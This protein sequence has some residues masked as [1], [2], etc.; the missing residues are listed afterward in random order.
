MFKLAPWLFMSTLLTLV[1]CKPDPVDPAPP[2]EGVL[3]LPETPFNYASP[4]LPDFMM[5]D[6]IQELDNIRQSPHGLGSYT[7]K[8]VVLQLY[9]FTELC[10]ILS[11]LPRSGCRVF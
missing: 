9:Y 6:S 10:H 2:Y 4:E 11:F 8:G 5:V 7:G 3:T 1:A